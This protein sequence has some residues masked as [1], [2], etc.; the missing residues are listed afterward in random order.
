MTAVKQTTDLNNGKL[1]DEINTIFKSN[2][3]DFGQILNGVGATDFSNIR[4]IQNALNDLH[5]PCAVTGFLDAATMRAVTLFQKNQGYLNEDTDGI[6]GP[7]TVGD[8][9]AVIT[10]KNIT[11]L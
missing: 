5:Y 8:L 4:T 10:S 6:P 11:L 1:L 9:A 3:F 7:K 2:G